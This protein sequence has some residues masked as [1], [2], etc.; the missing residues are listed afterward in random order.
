MYAE[1]HA[2]SA[3]SFLDGASLPEELAIQAHHL[4]LKAVALTDHNGLYGSMALAQAAKAWGV[5][6]IT[7][8]EVH[9]KM[10]HTSRCWWRRLG[11]TPTFAASSAG[12]ISIIPGGILR[13][14]GSFY[15]ATPKG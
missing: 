12:L 11:V 4:K 1:L 2:H 7:G 10:G 8:A 9:S 14:T 13:S 6:P 5:Q 3:Y 15:A